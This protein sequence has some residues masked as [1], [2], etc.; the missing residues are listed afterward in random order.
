VISKD[1]DNLIVL[2]ACRYDTFN[3]QNDIQGNL[4][5]RISVASNTNQFFKHNFS[6]R[7]L[8]D[9]IYVTANPTAIGIL[10]NEDPVFHDVIT[11]L[12]GYLSPTIHPK[13]VTEKAIKAQ[14]KYDD[15]NFIIHYL[16]PHAPF[17][18]PTAKK[19]QEYLGEPIQPVHYND[20]GISESDLWTAYNETLDITLDSVENLLA[21]TPGKT[22]ITADHG[23]LFRER[24]GPFGTELNGHPE[25]IK[26][27]G[28]RE[29]PWLV[30][31]N[32][33]RIS[34]EA[35]QPKIRQTPDDDTIKEHMEHLGY[36]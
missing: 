13:N 16:Q 18:G 28:L 3:Q 35:E 36:L 24:V 5:K 34:T 12:D 30:I 14:K 33:D 17:I 7:E 6:G 8:H 27:S 9:T 25:K 29:V 15:K 21:E 31:D 4:E 32:G 26:C 20:G 23:E 11:V 1:W 22:A 2:D 19:L 10:K